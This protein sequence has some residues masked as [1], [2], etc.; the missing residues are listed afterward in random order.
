MF[1]IVLNHIVDIVIIA[2]TVIVINII[3]IYMLS[4]FSCLLLLSLALLKLI[5]H[6]DIIIMTY[7]YVL[8]GISSSL[9]FLI[10]VLFSSLLYHYYHYHLPK[11]I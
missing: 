8:N 4:I 5:N 10:S 3:Y 6:A 7:C 2:I 1:I 9:S 11:R